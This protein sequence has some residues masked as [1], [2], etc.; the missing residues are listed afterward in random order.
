[1][2]LDFNT[3]LVREDRMPRSD[4][5]PPCA[6]HW[7]RRPWK[8]ALWLLLL[9]AVA[10]G[11]ASQQWVTLR[12]EPRNPLTEQL[13]LVARSGPQPTK[14]TRL[15]LRKYD[16]EDD[17]ERDPCKLAS[18]FKAVIDREPSADKIYA[19]A[20]LAY[21]GAKRE[22][23]LN[24][25]KALEMY[26]AAVMHAYLYLFDDH[27]GRLRNPYDPEFRGSCDLYNESLESALRIIKKANG[28]KAGQTQ[29]IET[30]NRSVELRIVVR[31]TSWR[32]EDFEDFEFVSDYKING[33]RNQYHTY[34]LGVPLVA[35][36]KKERQEH[37]ASR[38]YPPG[39]SVPVTAFLRVMPDAPEA[40][41]RRLALLELYDPLV[42]SD[43]MIAGRRVPLE[44]DLSTPLAYSLNQP[45]LRNLDQSTAGLI[46]PDAAEK[47]QGLYMLEPYQPGKIPV[48]MVHGI[49]SSPI[50]W[51]EM[52]NDLRSAPEVRD[53]YQFWFYLYPT[54]QPF[55]YS[56][57][58]LR[59]DL[60]E[61]RRELDPR[62][63]EPA[64]DQMILVGH[65]MGGL[66]SKL[67]V[68]ESGNDFWNIVSEKP[69][70]T[71]QAS[72]EVRL[73]LESTFF[74]HPNPSVRRVI[75][76][77]TPHR[78]S[79]FANS[80]T[81][82]IGSRLITLPKMLVNGRTQLVQDNPGLF[83]S[84]NVIE[85]P[86]SIDSLSPNCPV[87][88]VMLTANTPPWIKFHN[89]VGLVPDKGFIGRVAGG[90]DGIVAF[91]SAH[92]DNV[93]SEIVVNADH[94]QIHSHPRSVLEV[95]RILLEH[96]S[97]LKVPPAS[98]LDRQPWTAPPWT[99]GMEY[100]RV[101]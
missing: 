5:S 81:R 71:V 93:A 16:L 29:T 37:G 95:R 86:T 31:S 91:N 46:N 88:P 15:L 94:V 80:T 74:F 65:S 20:E 22:E 24:P 33:L 61:M 96:L 40:G 79:N 44:T 55:W 39:L 51:M 47:A 36:S 82:F 75:T 87:L 63:S 30:A 67:Q 8:S 52:F 7:F 14:R 1:M 43:I 49:W 57:K 70:T 18:D 35:V 89:I 28:L 66:V 4:A 92:L 50:T 34:G 76:I 6:Q 56:A 54:G 72:N 13:K 98:P 90:S 3:T 99:A 64:L 10:G 62:H 32:A 19:A 53:R 21:I 97:E 58:Q 17:L 38:Y 42:S 60:A 9:V 48:L 41:T 27:L 78:G 12:E 77:G 59:D 26:G 68:I 45:E 85:I 11:C 23:A 73:G 83:R 25:K 2:A 101:R 100:P 69:F 84:D